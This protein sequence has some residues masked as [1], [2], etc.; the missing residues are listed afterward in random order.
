MPQSPK[1]VT[2]LKSLRALLP[3]IGH[4][5]WVVVADAAY[6]LQTSPGIQTVVSRER[7][8]PVLTKVLSELQRARH[9]R[10]TILFDEELAHLSD[11]LAPGIG[12][13]RQGIDSACKGLPSR[14]RPHA[15]ILAQL[16]AAGRR[17][18]VLVIKCAERLPYTSVFIELDCGYW[19]TEA[20]TALR[21][22][23]ASAT[24]SLTRL[25]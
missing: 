5:N 10:P 8:V 4:R 20:E 6:P 16:E 19:D 13:L 7:L 9:I 24:P 14:S 1:S 25:P 15:K 17:F 18:H 3:V 2:W 22:Q 12:K 23:I 21:T 11:S